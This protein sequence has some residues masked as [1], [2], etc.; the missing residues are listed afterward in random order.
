MSNALVIEQNPEFSNLKSLLEKYELT[1]GEKATLFI[2][3]DE[4]DL[5]ELITDDLI[6][7]PFNIV[8]F[9]DPNKLIEQ[10]TIQQTKVVVVISDYRM[11]QMNGL[12][13]RKE[14]NKINSKSIYVIVSGNVDTESALKGIEY[15]ISCF[16][17]KPFQID[18]FVARIYD[19]LVLK[20]QE[21]IDE[22]ELLVGFVSDAENLIDQAD[23]LI[24]DLEDNPNNKEILNNIFG[25]AHT[26]KGSS[27][28]FEPKSLHRFVHAVEDR[29]KIEQKSSHGANQEFIDFLFFSFDQIKLL[30]KEFKAGI[31]IINP[32]QLI[33]N[34]N[35][36]KNRETKNNNNSTALQDIQ[37]KKN[38]D[39]KVEIKILDEFLTTSGEMTV[40]R[41]MINKSVQ[42]LEKK[43]TGERDVHILAELL[44][45]L[46]KI[47]GH[48]QNRITE[49][50]KISIKNVIKSLPRAVRDI[51]KQLGKK[52][53]L[54]ITGDDLR[55]DTSIA[56]VLSSSLI[57]MIRNS[58][59]HGLETPE[60]RVKLGKN[61]QGNIQIKSFQKDEL[62]YI[63]LIDDGKGI[64]T[65]AV[66]KRALANNLF[67]QDQLA[68]M[69]SEQIHLLIFESGF[70]TAEKIT[71]LSGRGVGM[72]MVKASVESV[73]GHIRIA[74][75]TGKGTQFTLVLPVPKSVLIKNCLFIE[76]D[77]KQYGLIQD[78]VQR[79]IK[80]DENNYSENIQQLEGA[81]VISINSI[82]YPLV[83]FRDILKDQL[84]S[85]YEKNFTLILLKDSSHRCFAIK[86]DQIID[87]EDTVIKQLP[88]IFKRSKIYSGATF[89]NDGT[90]GLVLSTDGISEK[91][92]KITNNIEQTKQF[93][94][95]VNTEQA[96]QL[97]QYIIFESGDSGVFAID[98][99]EI[100]RI[101]NISF[102]ELSVSSQNYVKPY[103]GKMMT[104]FMMD[105]L[106]H[107]VS[108]KAV[109]KSDQQQYPVLVVESQGRFIGLFIK[110]IN[111]IVETN[112][113]LH[114]TAMP[115]KGIDGNMIISNRIVSK[116]NLKE[117]LDFDVQTEE[118]A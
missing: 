114:S 112:S 108:M 61:P 99:K 104:C 113:E 44:E 89:M 12:D 118:V 60:E 93:E 110:N 33:E 109:K 103:R 26:I 77:K 20:I 98:R 94:A 34:L 54:Q 95:H 50:R 66:K 27:A 56:E 81:T 30:L 37:I 117:I 10:F 64:N 42:S 15:K 3:D 90:V 83:D 8:T 111:D 116:L 52:A 40:I 48:L 23:Q 86:V 102:N 25:V 11:P 5:L 73:G 24:L 41:N 88:E 101:E 68:K 87:F 57:H 72:S 85:I 55:V 67:N 115:I 74:S 78:E 49:I 107:G 38:E 36:K 75:Q 45:E 51:T 17:N 14:I 65:E 105:D 84:S 46:N 7:L 35:T 29:L 22:K 80:I 79:I 32:D 63:E 53:D 6:K 96:T 18:E 31:F 21:K 28:F 76:S 1:F 43:F 58:L 100:Y 92:F 47:N 97:K 39:I 59:D 91:Y 69:N 82:L 9:T 4:P 16:L 62:I 106:I 19:E 13:L 70:S 71:D 2:V